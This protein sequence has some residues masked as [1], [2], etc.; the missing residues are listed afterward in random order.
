MPVDRRR[1]SARRTLVLLCGVAPA[2]LTVGLALYRPPFVALADF[3]VYDAMLRALPPGRASSR[4]A[5]VDIDERSL[6]A[7]GQWPWRRDVMARLTDKLHELGAAAIAF[8]I[9]FAE[10]DRHKPG[11]LEPAPDAAFARALRRSRAV[12][13]YAMTFGGGPVS[14]GACAL[15]PVS[16][17]LVQPQGSAEPPVFRANGAICSLPELA[18][19]AGASGFLNATP[20]ADGILRR[21]PLLVEYGGHMYPGLAL[22]TVM[23]ATGAKG[24]A[25]HTLNLNTTALV[26]DPTDTTGSSVIPLDGRSNLLVRYRGGNRSLPYVSAVDVLEGRPGAAKLADALVFVGAT[27]IGAREIV[28]TPFDSLF[29]G[30]EA[31]ATVADN[32]LRQDFVSRSPGA[33]TVELCAVLVLGIA[34]TLLVARAG[35]AWGTLGGGVALLLIWRSVVWVLAARGEYYSP[36]FPALGLV[37]SL[38]AATI[39]KLLYERGRADRA[40]D[41]KDLARRLMVQ[42][43]LSLTEIRDADT[44]THSRRTQRYSRLLAEQLSEHPRFREYLTPSQI[45]LFSSLAPLHDIGKVGVPDQLLNKPG[46]LTVEEFHEMQKH[47]GYG[48]NVITTAQSNAGAQDDAILDLAKDIVYTHHER[49]DGKGYPRGLKG[50]QIPVAGRLMAIVDVYDALTTRRRYRQPL[51]HDQAVELIVNGYGTHFDPD[52]VDAFLR[53]APMMRDVAMEVARIGLDAKVA[54]PQAMQ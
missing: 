32:L 19:A 4:V 49:W 28:S 11:F 45:S 51:S 37:A 46:S 29:T 30:V 6:A 54:Q 18:R 2:L 10:P 5:I 43:L 12:L 24:V 42:S 25:V 50:D 14:P 9:V 52:V 53:T 15:H 47:P 17:P 22:A 20:D 36:L 41:E 39:A 13:G 44:G 34:I 7:V 35:L 3:R 23:A 1:V 31:H 38:G 40:T 48:L 21:V 8:D 27:A 26:V 16:I 33:L